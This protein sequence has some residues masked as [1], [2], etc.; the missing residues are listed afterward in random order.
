MKKFAIMGRHPGGWGVL[1]F[2]DDRYSAIKDW[3]SLEKNGIEPEFIQKVTI[4]DQ[5]DFFKATYGFSQT[6]GQLARNAERAGAEISRR[7]STLWDVDFPDGSSARITVLDDQA[8]DF[9]NAWGVD[10]Y[11]DKEGE[12]VDRLTRLGAKLVHT[13][14]N[15]YCATFPDESSLMIRFK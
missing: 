8:T 3:P 13:Y 2:Y 11:A 14:A 6:Y 1:R 9:K 10:F 7:S 5:A 12:V 15:F 4:P